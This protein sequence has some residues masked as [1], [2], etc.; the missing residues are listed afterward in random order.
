MIERP[1]GNREASDGCT[2]YGHLSSRGDD[3]C[4][5][6]VNASVDGRDGA[7]RLIVYGWLQQSEHANLFLDSNDNNIN[8]SNLDPKSILS[9]EIKIPQRKVL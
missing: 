1:S 8:T 9:E 2:K 5:R 6:I 7:Y 3:T 4:H